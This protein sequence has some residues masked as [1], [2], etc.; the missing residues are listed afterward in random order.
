M[1]I[2]NP[3]TKRYTREKRI[4]QACADKFQHPDYYVML[5][6][7]PYRFS[8]DCKFVIRKFNGSEDYYALFERTMTCDENMTFSEHKEEIYCF[9]KAQACL[10]GDNPIIISDKNES[11]ALMLKALGYE[12]PERSFAVTIKDKEITIHELNKYCRDSYDRYLDDI[13]SSP[14]VCI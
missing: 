1:W 4:C 6:E 11:G 8:K 2:F 5:G 10:L 3:I 12:I 14:Y 9:D 13:E 7:L